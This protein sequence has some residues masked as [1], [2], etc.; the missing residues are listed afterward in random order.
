VTEDG[1]VQKR[2]PEVAISLADFLKG[3][4]IGGMV[5]ESR[6]AYGAAKRR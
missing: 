5:R 2:C 4:Q 6:A 1:P 3:P